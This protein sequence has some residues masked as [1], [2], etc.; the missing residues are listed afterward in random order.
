MGPNGKSMLTLLVAALFALGS[1]VGSATEI[2]AKTATPNKK[3]AVVHKDVTRPTPPTLKKTA[4]AASPNA[5]PGTPTA[6]KKALAV[7]SGRPARPVARKTITFGTALAVGAPHNPGVMRVH[8][9]QIDYHF[10][11]NP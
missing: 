2:S 10:E 4:A 8:A 1:I 9:A 5:G 3:V 11:L 7:P 6:S